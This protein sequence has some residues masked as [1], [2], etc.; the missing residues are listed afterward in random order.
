MTAME[1]VSRPQPAQVVNG[2]LLCPVCGSDRLGYMNDLPIGPL[3][4][5]LHFECRACDA[6]ATLLITSESRDCADLL[7]VHAA[8]YRGQAL[9]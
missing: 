1:R 3:E 2:R 4:T 7:W 8:R 5:R 9:E 6:E